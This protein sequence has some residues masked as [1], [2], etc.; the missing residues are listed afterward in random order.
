VL[1]FAFLQL[2]ETK[3]E[4]EF[5][6]LSPSQKTSCSKKE[7]TA[8]FFF[9]FYS[10]EKDHGLYNKKPQSIEDKKTDFDLHTILVPLPS[11]IVNKMI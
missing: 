2:L 7:K 8:N 1:F 6:L 3:K 4:I 10:S 9:L 11:E 5:N